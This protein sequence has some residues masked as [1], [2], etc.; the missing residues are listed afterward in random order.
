MIGTYKIFK[1]NKLVVEQTNIITNF[2]HSYIQKYLAGQ[3]PSIGDYIAVGTLNTAPVVTDTDLKFEFSRG[4]ILVRSVNNSNSTI[5][6]KGSIDDTVGGLIWELGLFPSSENYAAG[7]AGSQLLILFDPTVESYSAGTLDAVNY[8]IGTA[9]LALST[10]TS[11]TATNSDFSQDLSGYSF[12]DQF[13]LA[14]QINDAFASNIE[15]RIMTDSGN[16]FAHTITPSTTSGYYVNNFTKTDFSSVGTPDWSNIT[17]AAVVVTASGGTTNVN[18]DG[19]NIVDK[20]N[21]VDYGLVS[22][23]VLTTP[24]MKLPSEIYDIEYSV[25]VS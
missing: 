21:Y 1:N 18:I 4:P 25:A 23:S 17:Q 16:Y 20:D 6:V 11:I 2:G 24:I 19:L 13:G 5:I 12:V 14:Y 9:S 15:L 7:G 22:R 8:R 3:V 10:A